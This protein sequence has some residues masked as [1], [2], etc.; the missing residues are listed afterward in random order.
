[1][2]R[3]ELTRSECEALDRYL[4][5]NRL[6]EPRVADAFDHREAYKQPGGM[7]AG[8]RIAHLRAEA[9]AVLHALFSTSNVRRDER[10]R[11]AR[12]RDDGEAVRSE[13]NMTIVDDDQLPTHATPL[14]SV[15]S[16]VRDEPVAIGSHR[17]V[18]GAEAARPP[19]TAS[20]SSDPVVPQRQPQLPECPPPRLGGS[21]P[22]ADAFPALTASRVDAAAEEWEQVA[23][24]VLCSCRARTATTCGE[25]AWSSQEVA[26]YKSQPSGT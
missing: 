16:S 9:D 5:L 12:R 21:L 2:S 7:Q 23:S 3:R 20:R 18:P 8:S 13:G 4:V 1:M 22:H 26:A 15:T 11:S 6:G 10:A 14:P 17:F 25:V 19:T 24:V